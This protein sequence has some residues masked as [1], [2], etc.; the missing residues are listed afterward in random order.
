MLYQQGDL[1]AIPACHCAA[2]V[3][4]SHYSHRSCR[5]MATEMGITD[6]STAVQWKALALEA[7]QGP[8]VTRLG[9][10]RQR[11]WLWAGG[12]V[13]GGFQARTCLPTHAGSQDSCRTS[14]HALGRESVLAGYGD[15]GVLDVV[16]EPSSACWKKDMQNAIWMHV[17]KAK[18][19][20]ECSLLAGPG[21][22][23]AEAWSAVRAAMGAG[24]SLLGSM[25]C[26][27]GCGALCCHAR[28]ICE[29]KGTSLCCHHPHSPAWPSEGLCRLLYA[30]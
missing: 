3:L 19:P 27:L 20:M 28:R 7:L 10:L 26:Q 23:P 4:P 24:C 9:R 1:Y 18:R 11:Q 17:L 22:D 2:S 29:H 13:L 5:G 8:Q 6:F 15:E 30:G 21:G 12:A 16:R 14:L 25:L